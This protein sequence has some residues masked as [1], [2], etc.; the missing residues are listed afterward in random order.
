MSLCHGRVKSRKSGLGEVAEVVE[1]GG[2]SEVRELEKSVAAQ[3]M[4]EG[5][6]ARN[7]WTV[8]HGPHGLWTRLSLDNLLKL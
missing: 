4:P 1:V 6:G 7:S 2:V 5:Q 3:P 8:A